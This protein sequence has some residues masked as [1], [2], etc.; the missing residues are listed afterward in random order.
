MSAITAKP[1]QALRIE[2]GKYYTQIYLGETLLFSIHH[3]AKAYE[4]DGEALKETAKFYITELGI[5]EILIPSTKRNFTTRKQAE[6]ACLNALRDFRT[7]LGQ[8]NL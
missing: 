1:I 8:L 4:D 3:V 7:D 5:T 6:K 2:Q